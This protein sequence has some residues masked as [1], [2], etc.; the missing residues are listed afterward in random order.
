MHSKQSEAAKQYAAKKTEA[1]KLPGFY[2]NEEDIVE[3]PRF[4]IATAA[5]T[6]ILANSQIR[7]K[8]ESSYVEQALR[9]ADLFMEKY[10]G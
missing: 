6:G 7:N 5:L 2:K 9:Y 3:T 1:E 4:K 8:G 10:N